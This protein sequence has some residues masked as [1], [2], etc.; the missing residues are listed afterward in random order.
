MLVLNLNMLLWAALLPFPTAVLAEHLAA[1][2]EPAR[3][4]A[5]L[6]SGVLVLLALAGVALFSWVIHDDRLHRLPPVVVRT[7]RVQ[8]LAG[9]AMYGVAFVLSWVSP[10]S[11][12]PCAGRWRSTTAATTCVVDQPTPAEQDRE[13][14]GRPTTLVSR[15]VCA[16][17]H[18][19]RR[20][21]PRRG[22]THGRL[23]LHRRRTD[24][25][26]C[27]MPYRGRDL[28]PPPPRRPSPTLE[29]SWGRVEE[30][31]R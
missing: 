5:T 7:T 28:L 4:A 16:T 6:Y 1:G 17:A 14:S 15:S 23:G 18:W 27:R 12:W 2:G 30:T 10:P 21:G 8:F 3:T 31:A 25:V 19:A 22:S 11:A 26:N 29:R 13:R 24:A 20:P 9:L